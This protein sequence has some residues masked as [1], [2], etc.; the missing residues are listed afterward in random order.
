VL[1]DLVREGA[2]ADPDQPLVISESGV[3]T[4]SECAARSEA[5]ARGLRRKAV[6]RFACVLSDP[7]ELLPLL[8]A[9]SAV[10]AEPCVYRP[11]IE[12]DLLDDFA[13][14]FGHQ[15]IVSD[16]ALA[17]PGVEVASLDDLADAGAAP[18]APSDRSPILV[19]T[20]G[21]TGRPKAARHDWR[22]LR[23]AVRTRPEMV[24][25]RWLLAYNVNQ[26]AGLQILLH[27]LANRA[28]LVVPAS[29]QPRDGL[30]AIRTHGV[31][32]VSATPTFWRM[33]MG[34]LSEADAKDLSLRQI[35]L[36]GE[37]VPASLL[38]D[39]S[40]LFP[41]VRVSQVYASTEFGSTTSVRD[42]ENG[43]PAAVLDQGEDADVRFRVVDGEL[44]V[45]SRVGMLGYFGQEDVTDDWRPTGDLVEVRD[46]R[47]HFVGRVSEV[48][49]VGGVK[50]HPLPVE[51]TVA[52]VDGVLL[53]RAYGRPNAV[54]GEIMAVDV[55]LRE[56]ADA[57]ETKEAIRAACESLPPAARPRRIQFVDALADQ[58]KINRRREA[59]AS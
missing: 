21:T 54:T 18:P 59:T 58:G 55:V 20:T 51:E 8:C 24:G 40:R 53:A 1:H 35:T 19:L 9:A 6:E 33:A 49:N 32:H 34:L 26:F 16:R 38:T 25:T 17:T 7:A 45:A 10:G 29:N 31:T 27:V 4:Y 46:G 12:D 36:G 57:D 37:A 56:G 44:F 2:H 11:T 39:L 42:R 14:T 52:A 47:I 3:L 13:R 30:A 5:L 22:R 50:V 43:L 41:D 48:V 15:V 23:A 28:T